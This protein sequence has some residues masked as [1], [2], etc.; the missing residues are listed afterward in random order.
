MGTMDGILDTVSA[1]HP[2][3][4]LLGLLKYHGKLIL[5]GLPDKPIE[6]PCFP[7]VMGKLTYIC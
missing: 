6:I 4:P 3:L 1:A 5:V 2:I 7:L